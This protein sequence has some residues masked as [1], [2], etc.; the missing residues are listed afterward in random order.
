MRIEIE[1]GVRLYDDAEGVS[2]ERTA[3]G[4]R[5]KPTLLLWERAAP[6]S[7]GLPQ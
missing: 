3:Q 5:H 1:P 6:H 4:V 2:L 7:S